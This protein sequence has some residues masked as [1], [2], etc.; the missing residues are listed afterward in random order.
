MGVVTDIRWLWRRGIAIRCFRMTR[1]NFPLYMRFHQ[2][3]FLVETPVRII[4][5]KPLFV[6]F[7]SLNGLIIAE[8]QLQRSRRTLLTRPQA[9][10]NIVLR[11][12]VHMPADAWIFS[13]GRLRCRTVDIAQGTLEPRP[14]TITICISLGPSRSP[15]WYPHPH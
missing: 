11:V 12:P 13:V 4:N 8:D 2:R 7:N 6:T 3:K 9:G 15:H 14:R 1:D 10:V 5:T